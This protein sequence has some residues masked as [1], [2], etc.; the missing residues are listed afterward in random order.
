MKVF[1]DEVA[2]EVE[3]L[4]AHR[5]QVGVSCS[6]RFWSTLLKVGLAVG[7]DNDSLLGANEVD[8]KR[9][10]WFLSSELV[11]EVSSPE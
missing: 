8:D 7:F 6:V 5:D 4:I 11:A 3:N 1:C 9:A 10:Y 2:A